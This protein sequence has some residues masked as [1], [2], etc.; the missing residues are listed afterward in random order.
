MEELCYCFRRSEEKNL[1]PAHR[2]RCFAALENIFLLIIGTDGKPWWL[3]STLVEMCNSNKLS[4]FSNEI[5]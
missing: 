1:A 3:L 4:R 5:I 2:T